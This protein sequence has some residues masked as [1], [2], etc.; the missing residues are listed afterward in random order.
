M[1]RQFPEW[2]IRE[3]EESRRDPRTFIG[4]MRKCPD[5]GALRNQWHEDDCE[6]VNGN[7]DK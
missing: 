4:P 5:C 6:R 7:E 2:M 3:Y 1:R